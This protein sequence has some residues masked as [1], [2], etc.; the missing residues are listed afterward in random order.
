[1]LPLVRRCSAWPADLFLGFCGVFAGML[2]WTLHKKI[3][4]NPSNSPVVVKILVKELERVSATSATSGSAP[5]LRVTCWR[6]QGAEGGMGT[7][8]HL[9]PVFSEPLS[10]PGDCGSQYRVKNSVGHQG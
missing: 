9:R 5:P 8:L 4:Q 2:R 7:Q 1:M 3:D 10:L 6:A